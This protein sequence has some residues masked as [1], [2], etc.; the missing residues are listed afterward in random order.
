MATALILYSMLT[1]VIAVGTVI[2]II[3]DLCDLPSA[4]LRG[5]V[6]RKYDNMPTTI[7]FLVAWLGSW[8]YLRVYV[9]PTCLIS[10]LY[11]TSLDS[12]KIW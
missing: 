3:H 8:T 1:N 2:L 10:Q 7:V 12:S 11:S 6:D 4:F 5:F 9:F